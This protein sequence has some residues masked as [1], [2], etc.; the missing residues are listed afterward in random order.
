M[1]SGRSGQLPWAGGEG[2][3]WGQ[4]SCHQVGPQ[5]LPLHLLF[6]FVRTLL[7]LL[8]S[9]SAK[10]HLKHLT[11]LFSF[12]LDFAKLGD[13]EAEF[14]LSIQAIS[15]CVEFYLKTCGSSAVQDTEL[16]VSD[17]DESEE[18]V[19]ALPLGGAS[20]TA[21]A[22][23]ASLDKMVSLIALLV[24][25][26]RGEDNCIHL[27]PGDVQALTSG[28]SL[29]FLYNITRDNINIRQ[30]CNL[31]FSLTRHNP[32]LAEHVAE[33]VF[34]GVKSAEH[35]LHFFRLL[36]LLTEV[37]GGP[38]GLPCFTS[39]IMHRVW[40]LAKSCPQAALD[41]LSIQVTR[42]RYAQTWL[43]G[44]LQDWVEHHLIAHTNVK[45]R[46]SAAFLLV[47]LVPSPHFRQTF[48]TP[49]N[50]PSQLRDSIEAA[51]GLDTITRLL[52]FLLSLLRNCK[53]Y[54]DI[55]CHGT[56]KLVSY[57]QVMT[58][59]LLSRQEKQ[60]LGPVFQDLWT[61]FH[62]KLSEPSIPVHQNKQALLHF[63]YTACL[64]C[65]DNVKLILASP[66]IVKN[67]AF[68]YILADHED[69]DV[70][71][72]NRAML[73][74]YYGLLR[75]CCTA[76][77][78]FCRT[79][80]QHQN[81]QWA[82]KNI[83]PYSTQYAGAVDELMKLMQLFVCQNQ[84]TSEEEQA[85]IRQFRTST[86]QLYLS[87]LDGRSSW[88]TLISVLKILIDS[89]ED[90]LF[91][92]CNNGL[93]LLY[94]A[95]NILHLM[96]HEATAC[97]V[98]QE[99]RELL[100]I[101]TELVRTVRS[102]SRSTELRAILARWKDMADMTSRLLTLCNSFSCHDLREVC[103]GAVKEMLLLWPNEMLTIL[104]PMFHRAH[105]SAADTDTTV[106]GPA[107][108][109]RERRPAGTKSSRP[110]RPMLQLAVP[111]NQLEA[112]HGQDSEY[113]R[114]LHHYFWTYHNL[115]DLMVRVAVN[116]DAINKMLIDL[117]AIV[118]LD[119]VPLHFQLFPKLWLDIYGSRNIDPSTLTASIALLVD[120]H[121]FLEYVDAVL[122]DERSSLNNQFVF[123][124]LLVFFPKVADQVLTEQVK[125]LIHRLCKNLTE[126]ATSY[127]LSRP[128]QVKHLNGDLRALLLV[129]AGV[130][131]VHTAELQ[132][133]VVVLRGRVQ[134]VVEGLGVEEEGEGGSG[135]EEKTGEE[136]R[137]RGEKR[138]SCEER[139]EGS[140]SSRRLTPNDR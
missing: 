64:D 54:I 99:L 12:L 91:T 17:D 71:N 97:H 48:R 132:Q 134:A 32:A 43:L 88:A 4:E 116:E 38:A 130:Q 9:G 74:T 41:W 135:E 55:S 35:S 23:T 138:K 125:S 111:A 109:R 19:I 81:I 11:E 117:S 27:S 31:I 124:F 1:A 122:L 127:D 52:E 45:V 2:Q 103:L 114:A 33:M 139:G 26:S 113:D 95:F 59:L 83:A 15:T 39:L 133:S 90:K 136:E 46:N 21:A 120:S 10:P 36:T 128:S 126:V 70:V 140:S 50:P 58:H 34:L 28:K 37:S 66:N 102:Q 57:F 3:D 110:P 29:L 78:P 13:Q 107:F 47:S 101:F 87:V 86:L 6:R 98:T 20:D 82:F 112:S 131:E 96:H 5:A 80:A 69:S 105:V 115:V 63:W 85:E 73:P 8:E 53:Q 7:H 40:D 119:G 22:R 44:S 129:Q 89:T 92:V 16:E 118:G 79:L 18:D 51:D 94:D 72:F 42:N 30:T 65:P 121:G 24:E 61:L 106:M 84:E 68:N 137:G 60:L 123:Q 14:L 100:A 93:S 75:L 104:V 56:T 77:R 76:S 67:I 108:P 49:R 62:P 25:R